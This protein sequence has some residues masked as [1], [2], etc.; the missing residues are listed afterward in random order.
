M[1][2]EF[3]T[4]RAIYL[5]QEIG[6]INTS[7]EALFKKDPEIS[8]LEKENYA[9]AKNEIMDE[10]NKFSTVENVS[11]VELL[12]RLETKISDKE[13]FQ[14]FAKDYNFREFFQ[15]FYQLAKQEKDFLKESW[16]SEEIDNIKHL[17]YLRFDSDVKSMDLAKMI[18][19]KL[20]DDEQFNPDNMKRYNDFFQPATFF[21]IKDDLSLFIDQENTEQ[22]KLTTRFKNLLQMA[23]EDIKYYRETALN[24]K[25]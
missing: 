24:E 13:N 7:L 22:V 14:N 20:K 5:D 15:H 6:N 21:S 3:E 25:K 18:L 12:H 2:K 4:D 16:S 11:F 1:Q 8:P 19:Q 17:L 23:D 9:I 10:I